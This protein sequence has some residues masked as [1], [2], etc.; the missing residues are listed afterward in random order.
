MEFD[1]L[2][3]ELAIKVSDGGAAAVKLA[4]RSVADFYSELMSTL[5]T[6]GI[7][8]EIWAQPVE[9]PVDAIPFPDDHQHDSYD[10]EHVGRLFRILTGVHT[11]LS[12]FRGEFIGKSSPVHFFWGSFD[13]AVTRFSGRRA[14]EQ[15]GMD[16]V[17]REGYS[18]ELTSCGF[19]P[20]GA[21]YTG[22]VVAEPVFYAYAAPAPDGFAQASVKPGAA[23]YST[24]FSEFMMPYDEI[25]ALAD[26]GK[27]IVQ[28]ARRTYVAAADLGDWDRESI[29][30][31]IGETILDFFG[32]VCRMSPGII[33]C[34]RLCPRGTNEHQL[35]PTGTKSGPMDRL[36]LPRFSGQF[37]IGDQAAVAQRLR[38]QETPFP[39]HFAIRPHTTRLMKN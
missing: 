37:N 9:I 38:G 13:L 22:A 23:A 21:W 16:S 14:P 33:L 11:V 17:T 26:P 24:E 34:P 10:P 20:G 31:A 32:P 19:W 12:Q 30:R 29:D 27:A 25:R 2:D 36:G 6:L 28:F 4:P 7:D 1:F 18:H 35:E 15:E 39:N 8:V 3:H 5:R